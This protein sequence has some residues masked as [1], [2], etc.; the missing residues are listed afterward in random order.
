M[1]YIR[2]KPQRVRG[3]EHEQPSPRYSYGVQVFFAIILVAL[4]GTGL[5]WCV[6]GVSSLVSGTHTLEFGNEYGQIIRRR[7]FHGLAALPY[8]IAEIGFG[9]SWIASC[10]LVLKRHLALKAQQRLPVWQSRLLAVSVLTLIACLL[11]L[12]SAW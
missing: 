10:V 11:V 9:L 12:F 1:R 6:R 8:S 7:T 3:A 4:V 2:K 5:I